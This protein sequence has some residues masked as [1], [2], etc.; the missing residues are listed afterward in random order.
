MVGTAAVCFTVPTLWSFRGGSLD[1]PG[2]SLVLPGRIK[3]KGRFAGTDASFLAG[4][5]VG[6]LEL[7]A[8]AAGVEVCAGVLD[9]LGTSTG[10]RTVGICVTSSAWLNRQLRRLHC[11]FSGQ[12]S[13][14]NNPSVE[15]M[16]VGCKKEQAV[17]KRFRAE[18]RY[19][20]GR[21]P[22]SCAQLMLGWLEHSW[23][24]TDTSTDPVTPISP[25]TRS[26]RLLMRRTGRGKGLGRFR[27]L[28]KPPSPSRS[29]LRARD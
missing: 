13:L 3:L 28:S 20:S 21:P 6:S 22:S 25:F 12:G 17:V 24:P 18:K 10:T 26:W 4:C 7:D 9:R 19:A 5:T 1:L 2:L 27:E 15:N 29:L 16:V 14:W 11:G 8:V 23:T